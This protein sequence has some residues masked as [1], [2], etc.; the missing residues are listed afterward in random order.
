MLLGPQLRQSSGYATFVAGR[1]APFKKVRRLEFTD[2]IPKS[3]SGKILRRVLVE[4]FPRQQFPG[5]TTIA[6]I[7]R[8]GDIQTALH[9]KDVLPM[10]GEYTSD[11]IV[12]GLERFLDA[13]LD[14]E[15]RLAGDHRLKRIQRAYAFESPE[16]LVLVVLFRVSQL[17]P[18][19]ES[20]E[21]RFG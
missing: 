4:R 15:R 7:L 1:V 11:T 6:T 13:A 14:G 5:A 2:Q 10:A 16:D 19:Q 17:Q 9:G 20:V 3:P 18:H 12:R 8:R 21:L